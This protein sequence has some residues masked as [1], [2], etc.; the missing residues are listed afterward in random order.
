MRR[1]ITAVLAGLVLVPQ[2]F[3]GCKSATEPEWSDDSFSKWVGTWVGTDAARQIGLQI[4]RGSSYQQCDIFSGC[5]DF[6]DLYYTATFSDASGNSGS[7]AAIIKTNNLY[8]GGTDSLE[9]DLLIKEVTGT[10]GLALVVYTFRGS[11]QVSG[12]ATGSV[13]VKRFKEVDRYNYSPISTELFAMT[14][15][16]Q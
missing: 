16:R 12:Q 9:F 7:A 15:R 4:G 6:S 13:V 8:G 11:I 2:L 1:R 10:P 5:H 3:A 14:L